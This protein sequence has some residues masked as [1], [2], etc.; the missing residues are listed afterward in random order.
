MRQ[1]KPLPVPSAL[2]S[3]AGSLQVAASPCWELALPDVVSAN[4][5]LDA[6]TCTAVACEVHMLVSSFTTSAFPTRGL[7]GSASTT[8]PL[9]TISCGA[10]FRGRRHSYRSGLQVCLPPRSSL[11]LQRLLQG[12]RGV[13]VRAERE[14]LPSHASDMLAVRTEQLTAGDFHPI[15]L[16]ALSTAPPSKGPPERW[17]HAESPG[18]R[19]TVHRA[20]LQP[21]AC[22]LSRCT[23]QNSLARISYALH[24]LPPRVCD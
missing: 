11:P 5:S 4:L 17:R 20:L 18:V 22:T 15:R 23:S 7:G 9:Q 3:F 2:A 8:A 1:T 10:P 6:W 13:Y 16:A 14:S 19:G 21:C 24:S 12:S